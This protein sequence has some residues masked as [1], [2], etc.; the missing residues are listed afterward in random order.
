MANVKGSLDK[1]FPSNAAF[2]RHMV[3]E[4]AGIRIGIVGLQDK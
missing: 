1:K 4:R 3:V 2:Q